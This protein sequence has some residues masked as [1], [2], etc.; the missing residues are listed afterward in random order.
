MSPAYPNDEVGPGTGT[1]KQSN[2]SANDFEGNQAPRRWTELANRRRVFLK[3]LILT[4]EGSMPVD[5]VNEQKS[6]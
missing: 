3:S 4:I 5:A 6:L 1:T 2:K